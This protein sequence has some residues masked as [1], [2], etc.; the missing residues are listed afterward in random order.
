LEVSTDGP[1]GTAASPNAA[2]TEWDLTLN[3]NSDLQLSQ[4]GVQSGGGGG[5]ASVGGVTTLKL[6]GAGKVG[7]GQDFKGNWQ[8]LTTIDST[9]TGANWIT[10]ATAGGT[11]AFASPTNP[12]GLFGSLAGLLDEGTGIGGGTFAVTA[13]AL[14]SGGTLLDASAANAI[15]IKALATTGTLVPGSEIIVANTVVNAATTPTEFGGI[16]GFDTLGLA[17]VATPP[18]GGT[19][20]DQSQLPPSF[21]TVIYESAANSDLTVNKGSNGLTV[22][23][24]GNN[25]LGRLATATINGLLV[26]TATL[27]LDFGNQ[28][29]AHQDHSGPITT[30]GYSTLA[31][32]MTGDGVALDFDSAVAITMSSTLV[33]T[34]TAPLTLNISGTQ[35]FRIGAVTDLGTAPTGPTSATDI[36]NVTD[37]GSVSL[38]TTNFGTVNAGPSADLL[39]FDDFFNSDI[40]GSTTGPNLLAGG[41]GGSGA[42][43]GAIDISSGAGNTLTGGS[44]HDVII[45]GIGANIVNLAATHSGAVF[46]AIGSLFGGV[47]TS[48]GDHANQGAWSV[49]HG[50]APIFIAGVAGPTTIFGT[51]LSQGTENSLTTINNFNTAATS[52]DSF[53]FQASDWNN[54]LGL[55]ALGSFDGGLRV[56]ST[57]VNVNTGDAPS[58]EAV[59]NSGQAITTLRANLIEISPTITFNGAAGLASQLQGPFD[60]KFGDFINLANVHYLIAY[61]DSGDHNNIHIADVDMYNQTGHVSGDS[62]AVGMHVYAS[63]LV[64]LTGVTT[65]AQLGHLFGTFA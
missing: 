23:F 43:A 12:G 58:I 4:G 29:L 5:V 18:V 33:G 2:Y 28:A 34:T 39:V 11:N 25:A 17:F 19:T 30:T 13:V 61:N 7:L 1:A 40:K 32:T 10:G 47:V 16:A 48:A 6:S 65:A 63:D 42:P 26:Q 50:S 9:S 3:A 64:G 24:H 31:I 21:K 36:I 38:G 37:T 35:D 20:L 59:A 54:T 44:A 56:V 55:N 27:N 60:L 41:D 22:D 62:N 15:E 53:H 57:I 14:G 51:A 49:T 52:T 46:V 8:K 45:T